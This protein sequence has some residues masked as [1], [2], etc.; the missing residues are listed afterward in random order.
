MRLVLVLTRSC[1]V[2]FV[3]FILGPVHLPY[4]LATY[5][6]RSPKS[7]SP[8]FD[9]NRHIS[10]LYAIFGSRNAGSANS[11]LTKQFSPI[12]SSGTHQF[13]FSTRMISQVPREI[14]HFPIERRPSV[15]SR[16][17]LPPNLHQLCSSPSIGG[18]RVLGTHLFELIQS[19]SQRERICP[20]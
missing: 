10:S 6:R 8:L 7:A 2:R 5:N 19:N 18:L 13:V 17:M 1:H 20:A 15:L 3:H 9:I 16:I 12:P 14:V 11:P 4:T